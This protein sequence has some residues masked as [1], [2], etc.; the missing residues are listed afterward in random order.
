MLI[1]GFDG[2]ERADIEVVRPDRFRHLLAAL[3][4][5]GQIV[6]RGAGLN[7]CLASGGG[8]ARSLDATLFNRILGFDASTGRVHVEAGIRLGDLYRFSV[9]RGWLLPIMPGHPSITV[10]GCIA[11]DIHGKNHCRE[12]N[13]GNSV[14][15]LTLLHPD[16]GEIH[17]S[18]EANPE[19][20]LLTIGGFGLTGLV[21]SAEL[22]LKRIVGHGMRIERRAVAGLGD[23]V[24]VMEQHRDADALYSWHNLNRRGPAFG[25]GFVYA[26]AQC[27][28]RMDPR[29]AWKELAAE[30][31]GRR[32]PSAF[33]SF[34]TKSGTSAYEASQRV[35]KPTK[36]LSLLAAT[37]PIR[38]KEIYFHLYGRR[39][40]REYQFL[41]PR[42]RWTETVAA[43]ERILTARGATVG[44]ASLKL[45]AGTG[46]LLR[47][48]GTGVC[49]AIDVVPNAAGLGTMSDLDALLFANHGLPNLAKDSRISA[50]TTRKLHPGYEAFRTGLAK[51]DPRRRMGS[52]LRTR[53]EL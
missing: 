16:H 24:E 9:P 23:A 29:I 27:E 12:G 17:C 20:F 15:A 6:P 14:V 36:T 35:S 26:G 39:G 10:G 41:V 47:F 13:F 30:T 37:F 45:F 50:A 51:F 22:Q 53:L 31:R 8:G 48:D 34:F 7:Y 52:A 40:F 4:G 2:N 43:V 21:L 49:L 28:A 18:R 38:G 42:E 44:L 19:A 33:A 32:Y 46:S 3:Q 25:R 5:E 1:A 11:S